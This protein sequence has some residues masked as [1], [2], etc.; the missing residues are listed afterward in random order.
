MAVAACVLLLMG[1]GGAFFLALNEERS[2]GEPP[3][4]RAQATAVKLMPEPSDDEINEG[5]GEVLVAL[6]DARREEPE[7]LMPVPEEPVASVAQAVAA[8]APES[9][10]EEAEAALETLLSEVTQEA[11]RPRETPPQ[12]PVKPKVATGT[13][14]PHVRPAL[15]P[16]AP[17]PSVTQL[18]TPASPSTLDRPAG[19]VTAIQ[20]D[21]RPSTSSPSTGANE[22]AL[23]AL[24]G[25]YRNQLAA[26]RDEADARRAWHLFQVD[27]GSVLSGLEPSIER[28][29]TANG[30][31]YRVQIG[32]S[33]T[34]GCE[35]ACK[36]DPGFGVIGIE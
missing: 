11:E 23:A 12:P 4:T 15:A 30:V 6:S 16:L 26:V 14:S 21:Q 3:L 8:T 1:G 7:R 20:R 28:A 22:P 25:P 27:L 5:T 19:E 2:L 24:E 13:P 17:Q 36:K 9:T 33:P 32:R 31:F 34:S 35:S 29:D 18:P 10:P